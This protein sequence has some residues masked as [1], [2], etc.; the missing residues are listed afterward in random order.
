MLHPL[1]LADAVD[2]VVKSNNYPRACRL[3]NDSGH[4]MF[5]YTANLHHLHSVEEDTVAIHFPHY[6]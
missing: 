5:Q 1:Q 4:W 2:N 3:L 6:F